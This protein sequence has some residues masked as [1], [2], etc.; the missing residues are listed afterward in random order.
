MSE[1]VEIRVFREADLDA[2]VE[3]SIRAW[4]PI[5]A[6]FRQALGDQIFF[7]LHPDWTE[8]QAEAVRSSCTSND[9]DAFVAIADERPVGFSAVALNAFHDRMGVIDIIAVDP[10]YQRRGIATQLMRRS[11]EHMRSNGMDIA[12]VGTGAARVIVRASRLQHRLH[13]A[14][15]YPLPQADRL[16]TRLRTTTSLQLQAI[17]GNRARGVVD[18]R[19]RVHPGRRRQ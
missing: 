10:D 2:I 4:E 9:L 19:A 15:G 1:P 14:A 11:I 16:A 7:R 13:A 6:A 8:I 5:Y 18:V 3:F 17:G 12:A